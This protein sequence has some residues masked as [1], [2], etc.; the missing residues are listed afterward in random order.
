MIKKFFCNVIILLNLQ[1]CLGMKRTTS[2]VENLPK[3]PA[4]KVQENELDR[5]F[6]LINKNQDVAG[7]IRDYYCDTT[8]QEICTK[9]AQ[10]PNAHSTRYPTDD[11]RYCIIKKTP[12][13]PSVA[14]TYCA[15]DTATRQLIPLPPHNAETPSIY[16][17][18][19]FAAT[20]TQL[21]IFH[22]TEN[23]NPDER[24]VPHLSFN[25]SPVNLVAEPSAYNRFVLI[26]NF[27]TNT[28]HVFNLA[29]GKL[30]LLPTTIQP[31]QYVYWFANDTIVM[32]RRVNSREHSFHAITGKR[33]M[34]KPVQIKKRDSNYTSP[35]YEDPNEIS[36]THDEDLNLIFAVHKPAGVRAVFQ[37]QP[38]TN[39]LHATISN[40]GRYVTEHLTADTMSIYDIKTQ[41]R[42]TI[43]LPI[44]AH[45]CTK[46][47]GL[48]HFSVARIIDQ[49]NGQEE[50][51]NCSFLY[52]AA[53]KTLVQTNTGN[54]QWQEQHIGKN[55]I[56]LDN[57]GTCWAQ[58]A[59]TATL[60]EGKTNNY[61][62]EQILLM[63]AVVDKRRSVDQEKLMA[64]PEFNS[65]QEEDQ[66][67]L[68]K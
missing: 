25:E 17:D 46:P 9:V 23:V 6:E 54:H 60:V 28:A 52:D 55:I 27:S 5:L 61:S 11:R 18:W 2:E 56:W 16:S 58:P 32:L 62:L 42:N 1:P 10:L 20:D 35:E 47:V 43:T 12:T 39:Y 41:T 67:W 49:Q 64:L 31:E 22:I 15:Y 53:T 51:Q 37:G 68:L 65:L 48:N 44:I 7:L 21:T 34:R 14:E 50:R 26:R 38:E 40:N 30:V 3:P 13:P 45:R 33:M 57:T 4:A 19:L 66:N 36:I 8:P 24:L 59:D 29:T 63:Q